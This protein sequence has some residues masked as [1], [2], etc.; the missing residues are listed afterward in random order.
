[1][2]LEG[3]TYD[4]TTDIGKVR[5]HAADTDIDSPIFDDSEVTYALEVEGNNH[6]RAAAML[7]ETLAANRSRL[8]I[9]VGRGSLNEN[10]TS[11][12]KELREQAKLLRE[13]AD[14]SDGQGFPQTIIS[15][16]YERFSRARNYLTGR[17][18]NPRDRETV[19]DIVKPA[20]TE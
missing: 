16:S 15:P 14:E 20:G 1:M 10:F 19:D 11:V 3:A 5:L 7:L 9:S 6:R 12:A 4:L 8:A 13:K 2:G 17:H 18:G